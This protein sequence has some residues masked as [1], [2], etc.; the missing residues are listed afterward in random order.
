MLN[1]LRVQIELSED[2]LSVHK[3]IQSITNYTNYIPF[4]TKY[5]SYLEELVYEEYDTPVSVA[6]L[7]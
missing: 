6:I 1:R 5:L 3:K 2:N 4:N 7:T